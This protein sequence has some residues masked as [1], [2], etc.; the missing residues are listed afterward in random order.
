MTDVVYLS[1]DA[2]EP[3]LALDPACC[4]VVGGLVDARVTLKRSTLSQAR[5]QGLRCARLPLQ[6]HLP[7][8]F[9]TQTHALDSLN[10]NAVVRILVEWCVCRDWSV[11]LARGLG[12]CQ[13]GF[14]ES[15]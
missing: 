7:E 8:R 11:A 15:H 6:E 1:P 4:Y 13:R 9:R 10:V 14:G 3:L 5:A 12:E 2:P